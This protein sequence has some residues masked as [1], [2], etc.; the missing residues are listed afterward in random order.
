ML[1]FMF[2]YKQKQKQKQPLLWFE[3]KPLLCFALQ[4]AQCQRD[5]REHCLYSVQHLQMRIVI[6]PKV[7]QVGAHMNCCLI[8]LY[9]PHHLTHST[10]A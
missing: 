2:V 1:Q 5:W 6:T 4:V 10:V 8:I 3:F 9:L 7:G